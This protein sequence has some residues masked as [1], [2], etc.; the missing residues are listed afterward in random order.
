MCLGASDPVPD[1]GFELLVDDLLDP[2]KLCLP[3]RGE[4]V[5]GGLQLGGP[6][7]YAEVMGG[8]LEIEAGLFIAD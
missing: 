4:M 6:N 5:E 3:S 8:F 2:G 7:R 1:V